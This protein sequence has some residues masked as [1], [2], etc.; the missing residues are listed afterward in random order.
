[1]GLWECH[2]KPDWLLTYKK[3]KQLLILVLVETGSHSAL[4]R[5]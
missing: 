5:K 2:I 1:M 4:F 3:N